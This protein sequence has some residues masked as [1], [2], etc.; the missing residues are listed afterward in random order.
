MT[1]PIR[2][3]VTV[4][5]PADAAFDLFTRDMARWWPGQHTQSAKSGGSPVKIE[6]EPHPGGR[7]TEVTPDGKRIP[8]GRIIGWEPGKYLSFT[9]FPGQEESDATVVAVAFTTTKD[10]TRVEL[11]Q[12]GPAILGDVADAVSTSY[13]RGWDLVLG[14]YHTCAVREL[15]A[16]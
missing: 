7:I 9:W 14:C 13:L 12:G 10:G 2:K 6:V 16:T 4:P 5:L 3:S 8:W 15:V 11:T 1:D